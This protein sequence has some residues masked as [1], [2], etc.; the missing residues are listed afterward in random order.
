[1]SILTYIYAYAHG[2]M[3]GNSSLTLLA[4][5]FLSYG[6]SQ[7]G[8]C[9]GWPYRRCPRRPYIRGGGFVNFYLTEWLAGKEIWW[10]QRRERERE[11]RCPSLQQG[12]R[13]GTC[14]RISDHNFLQKRFLEDL[15]LPMC[16]LPCWQ[17]CVLYVDLFGQF[18]F[19]VGKM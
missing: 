1:M 19:P 16:T 9:M 5:S 13:Y 15:S 18:V 14:I 17:C 10:R 4:R 12:T 8:R 2:G 6:F 3:Y 11:G 7:W